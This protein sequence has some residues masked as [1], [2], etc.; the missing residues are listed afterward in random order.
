MPLQC[1]EAVGCEFGVVF[2]VRVGVDCFC[3][4]VTINV[5]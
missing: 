1:L 2:F 5:E 3:P 4:L